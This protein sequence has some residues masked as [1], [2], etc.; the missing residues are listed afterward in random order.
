M[1]SSFRGALALLVTVVALS[2]PACGRR[3]LITADADGKPDEEPAF[4]A[5]QVLE[6]CGRGR[7]P[8]DTE[9]L[10]GHTCETLGFKGGEIACDPDTCNLDLTGCDGFDDRPP[11]SAGRGMGTAGAPPLFGG[12]AGSAPPTFGGL[13]GGAAGV[14]G[15]SG[16]FFGGGLFGGGDAGFFGGGFFGGGNMRDG[17]MPDDNPE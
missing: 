5:G 4:D 17:G 11:G 2:A 1:A 13:F 10:G 6:P 9:D 7:K 8:C 14:S 3:T 12:N 15:S 16:G